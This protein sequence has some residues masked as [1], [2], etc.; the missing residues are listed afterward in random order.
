MEPTY[1]ALVKLHSK[2]M[3]QTRK[4]R[5][6]QYQWRYLVQKALYLQDVIAARD[7][8]DWRIESAFARKSILPRFLRK[9]TD[10]IEWLYMLYLR[11]WLFRLLA[12]LFVVFFFVLLWCELN[13]ALLKFTTWL[14]Y[15]IN[16]SVF[17]WL[18]YGIAFNRFLVQVCYDGDG[19]FC[20][21][22]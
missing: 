18:S 20:V 9:L 4:Y 13:P 6:A 7:N 19:S 5:Q 12:L 2:V 21:R 1:R 10:R 16:F 11:K 17:Y 3:S 14:G 22:E 8:P 15:P